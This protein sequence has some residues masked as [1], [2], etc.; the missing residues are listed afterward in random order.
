MADIRPQ[1]TESPAVLAEGPPEWPRPSLTSGGESK[2]TRPGKDATRKK[3][4]T[5]RDKDAEVQ[6]LGPLKTG[7][8]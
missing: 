6:Y 1:P 3:R 7:Q 2:M 4:G 5:A 8:A